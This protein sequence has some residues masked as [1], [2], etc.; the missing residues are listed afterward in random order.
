ML[1]QGLYKGRDGEAVRLYVEPE[2]NAAATATV[3]AR[4]LRRNSVR[5]SY[6]PRP[7]RKRACVHS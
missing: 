3:R 4:Y 2:E 6:F 5:G 1:N 7:E